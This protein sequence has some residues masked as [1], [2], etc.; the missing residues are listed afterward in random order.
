[1]RV[2]WCNDQKLEERVQDETKATIRIIEEEAPD[3]EALKD[4][5]CFYSG[6]LANQRVLFAKAY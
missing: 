1:M 2:Y 4:K 3:A 6:K 5:K